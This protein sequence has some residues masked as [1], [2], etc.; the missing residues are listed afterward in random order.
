[1]SFISAEINENK[2]N[3]PE[4]EKPIGWT[5]VIKTKNITKITLISN[6]HKYLS[7]GLVDGKFELLKFTSGVGCILLKKRYKHLKNITYFLIEGSGDMELEFE[8][9]TDSF[10][11]DHI[12][13]G[14]GVIW[15]HLDVYPDKHK[16]PYSKY[17]CDALISIN[18]DYSFEIYTE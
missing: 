6:N 2:A 18:S 8:I 5:G 14:T 11:I 3:F 17:G 13:K 1:M 16:S 12:P 15:S 4:F 10:K 7:H 9:I